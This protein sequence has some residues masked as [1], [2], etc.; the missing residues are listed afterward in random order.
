MG[1]QSHTHTRSCGELRRRAGGCPG[2]PRPVCLCKILQEI[3]QKRNPTHEQHNPHPAWMQGRA[4]AGRRRDSKG[5]N[6]ALGSEPRGGQEGRAKGGTEPQLRPRNP[7]GAPAASC[8]CRTSRS[9]TLRGVSVGPPAG[10]LPPAPRVRR[11]VS[12]AALLLAVGPRGQEQRSHFQL[13]PR[14]ERRGEGERETGQ[15]LQDTTSGRKSPSG[16][17]RSPSAPLPSLLPLL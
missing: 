16:S 11:G 6:P 2:S 10:S 9:C 5:S 4:W 1:G 3:P 15:C 12:G 8:F 7:Q 17:R 14:R 13:Q